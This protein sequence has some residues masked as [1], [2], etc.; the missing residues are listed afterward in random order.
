MAPDLVA[1]RNAVRLPGIVEQ[2]RKFLAAEPGDNCRR[3]AAYPEDFRE[4]LDD[5]IPHIV[6]VQVVEFLEVIEVENQQRN[7]LP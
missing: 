5:A 4:R 6:A 2:N 1:Q 7:L 3:R